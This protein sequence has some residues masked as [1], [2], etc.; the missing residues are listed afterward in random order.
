LIYFVSIDSQPASSSTVHLSSS[1]LIRFAAGS[2]FG[3][4]EVERLGAGFVTGGG[5]GDGD[6]RCC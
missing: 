5:G 2:S 4:E 3:F 1:K 6:R